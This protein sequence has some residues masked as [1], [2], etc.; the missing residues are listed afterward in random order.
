MKI[1]DEWRPAS[2]EDVSWIR[3]TMARRLV[4]LH[5]SEDILDDLQLIVSEIGSNAVMHGRPAPGV[6]AV[7]VDIEGADLR[8]EIEDDGGRFE[9]AEEIGSA[10]SSH[11][12]DLDR[13]SGRGLALARA[14]L[15][16][17]QHSYDGRNHFVGLRCLRRRRPT[18]LVVEDAPTLL[19]MYADY[20]RK[21]YNVIGC[22][23]L[24]EAR[25]ALR[26]NPIDVVVADIHLG[27]GLG[28]ELPGEV[29]ELTEGGA[30]PVVLLTADT[31][32]DMRQTALR[33]GAEFYLAKPVRARSLREA[34]ALAISRAD[35]R[36]ARLART[37]SRHVD[38]LIAAKLPSHLGS[39]SLASAGGT[40]ATGG[41]D[42]IVHLPG[43]AT[44]RIVV[45]D[46]M[47]H[48]V[49]A[50]AWAVAYSAIVR[51]LHHV[52]G[53]L[54]TSAFLT[55][56]ARIAWREPALAR[57]MATVL[58]LDMDADG[59]TMASAGHPHPIIFGSHVVRPQ[60]VAPLLGVLEPEP[61]ESQT[62]A[63]ASGDRMVVFTDGLDPVGVAAGGDPPAWFMDLARNLT[64][65]PIADAAT[66]LRKATETALGPQPMD[67]WTFLLIEKPVQA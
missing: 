41:G 17:V 54:S 33:G 63:L 60:T 55:E 59:V 56:L 26:S 7:R 53:G 34:V 66:R 13:I 49:S 19:D 27:D 52:C 45:I 21:D 10:A 11:P 42:L 1:F 57:A 15:D 58:I 14:A 67:D 37:F 61:Y 8:I 62:F 9:L 43:D 65:A 31:S 20:L 18:A 32:P 30:L 47:G 36:N 28:S 16:R 5:L 12:G 40:A 22:V 23:S 3:R 48:G 64:N 51:T 35:L 24:A 46:V 50:R 6:L 38:D 44:D 29:D 25:S 4:D 39:Y 2:L